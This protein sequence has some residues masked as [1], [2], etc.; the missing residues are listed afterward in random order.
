M[1]SFTR[2]VVGVLSLM[3]FISKIDSTKTCP[4]Y[5]IFAPCNCSLDDDKAIITCDKN[6]NENQIKTVFEIADRFTLQHAKSF[7]VFLLSDNNVIQSIPE[8]VFGN[9]IFQ[10]I[11]IENC[12][13]LSFVHPNA[14]GKTFI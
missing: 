13:L 10:E 12:P 6:I 9:L 8:N 7:D 1:G 14:F 2:I 4:T 5:N 3:S 11:S